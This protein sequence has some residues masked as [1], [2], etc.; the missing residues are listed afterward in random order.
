A[1]RKQRCLCDEDECCRKCAG[2]FHVSWREFRRLWSERCVGL[3]AQGLCD[4]Q[5]ALGQL[6]YQKRSS[7][8]T[9]RLWGCLCNED[10][11]CGNGSCLFDVSRRQ[12]GGWRLRNCRRQ[13]VQRDRDGCDNF[14]R[15]S[16]EK[17][18]QPFIWW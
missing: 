17:C 7:D 5:D 8:D 6:S 13:R 2:L 3:S 9:E 10:Q 11:C 18:H 16:D 1:R 15:L 14:P 12:P 4:R